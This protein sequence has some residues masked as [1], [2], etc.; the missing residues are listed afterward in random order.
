M[1]KILELC[2]KYKVPFG[3]TPSSSRTG[4]QWID[5]GCRFFELDSELGLIA[6]G[7]RQLVETYRPQ[8]VLR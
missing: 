6:N 8:G 4:V 1:Q 3:T 2:I 5:R 7:A